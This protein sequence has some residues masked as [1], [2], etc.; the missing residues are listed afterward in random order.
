MYANADAGA[1]LVAEDEHTRAVSRRRRPKTQDLSS[2]H[3][4]ASMGTKVEVLESQACSAY[5]QTQTVELTRRQF[6]LEL[7]DFSLAQYACAVHDPAHNVRALS[8]I[9]RTQDS[10]VHRRAAAHP[11]RSIKHLRRCGNPA[12]LV[13][14]SL[15]AQ[16]R[17]AWPSFVCSCRA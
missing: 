15:C 6:E 1:A 2:K 14:E 9:L 17:A 13:T 7:P 5:M 3:S 12:E 8:L 16:A 4:S 10:Q 11:E